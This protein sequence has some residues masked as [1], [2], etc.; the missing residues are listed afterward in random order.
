MEQFWDGGTALLKSYI[1]PFEAL[2]YILRIALE[3]LDKKLV[4]NLIV[5]LT[6]DGLKFLL[7]LHSWYTF[8]DNT[9][10]ELIVAL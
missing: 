4:K 3:R 9:I 7:L 6:I 5:E 10:W 1:A 8:Y 2:Q